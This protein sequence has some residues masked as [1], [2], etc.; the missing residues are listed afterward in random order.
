VGQGLQV[1]TRLQDTCSI[2]GVLSH[3]GKHHCLPWQVDFSCSRCSLVSHLAQ[4]AKSAFSLG[5]AKHL[6]ATLT[7]A[8]LVLQLPS[9]DN[10]NLTD[11]HAGFSVR[12]VPT[13]QRTR[14]ISVE[15]PACVVLLGSQNYFSSTSTLA[16]VLAQ[17]SF[18]VADLPP[19]LSSEMVNCSVEVAWLAT[20]MSTRPRSC[21]SS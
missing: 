7:C 4:G 11:H 19:V 10:R 2:Q 1:A 9:K 5:A 21:F 13:L 14:H 8:I 20:F 12:V 17:S 6:R 18:K 3:T 16:V 15:K